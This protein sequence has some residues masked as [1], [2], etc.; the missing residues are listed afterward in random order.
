[1]RTES[2]A[3]RRGFLLVLLCLLPLGV[4]SAA[5]VGIDAQRIFRNHVIQGVGTQCT[6][7]DCKALQVLLEGRPMGRVLSQ[8]DFQV[9]TLDYGTKVEIG[10]ERPEHLACRGELIPSELMAKLT[11]IARFCR[12]GF[13]PIM[14]GHAFFATNQAGPQL[15]DIPGDKQGPFKRELK[16]ITKSYQLLRAIMFHDVK[17]VDSKEKAREIGAY[18]ERTYP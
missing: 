18:F 16:R 4:A 17:T 6:D 5:P 14:L 12:P 13:H 8:A 7:K 3:H 15:W 2:T 9:E 11:P 10:E 1:M